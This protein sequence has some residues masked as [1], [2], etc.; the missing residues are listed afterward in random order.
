MVVVGGGGLYGVRGHL[1][2][3]QIGGAMEGWVTGLWC[4]GLRLVLAL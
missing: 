3:D 1:Y 2:V 4:G